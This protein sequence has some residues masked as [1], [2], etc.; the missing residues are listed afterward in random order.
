MV[1]LVLERAGFVMDDYDALNGQRRMQPQLPSC[2][3][4]DE[5]GADGDGLECGA[6]CEVVAVVVVAA[7]AVDDGGGGGDDA[8]YC[9]SWSNFWARAPVEPHPCSFQPLSIFSNDS[10][11]TDF[12]GFCQWGRCCHLT[13][14]YIVYCV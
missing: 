14:T 6:K 8:I 2:D 4:A 11:G 1:G 7:A 13:C 9:V 3:D 5:D 12:G 10:C